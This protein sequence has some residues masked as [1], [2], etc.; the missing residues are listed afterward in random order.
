MFKYFSLIIVVTITLSFTSICFSKINNFGDFQNVQ[1]VK[2]YDG[3]T[4][5]VNIP[6]VH[7]L[8]GYNIPVRV[9]GID[10]PEIRSH[11]LAEHKAALL[12]KNITYE[13]CKHS[14]C[15]VLKNVQRGKYFRIVADV[16]VDGK[17]LS[18]LLLESH[19]AVP[20]N[21]KTKKI[22]WCHF[23]NAK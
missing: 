21:G 8:I 1:F 15:I 13:I 7:P 19:I 14:H 5:T 4:I 11:C 20:Y 23:L 3:D 10:C 18:R 22:N 12:A 9:R 17:S 16:Y 6:N 2:N